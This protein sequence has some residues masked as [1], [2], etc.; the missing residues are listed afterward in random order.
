MAE[1]DRH[2]M[3]KDQ[4]ILLPTPGLLRKNQQ[5]EPAAE[6]PIIPVA[7]AG[8]LNA[9]TRNENGNTMVIVETQ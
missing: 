5:D 2:E 4:C 1:L 6:A 9:V 7:H 8:I 3:L